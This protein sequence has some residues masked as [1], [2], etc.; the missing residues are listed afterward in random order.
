MTSEIVVSNYFEELRQ[1]IV[2]YGLSDKPHMIFNV[3]EKGISQDHTPPHVISSTLVHPPAVTSGKSST[4]TI[5]GCGMAVPSY[6]VF[7]GKRMMSDLMTDSTPG[8]DDCV[9]DS[10]WSNSEVFRNYLE[11]HFLKFVPCHIDQKILLLLD[12][13]KLHISVGL[14]EWANAQGIILYILPAHTSHRLQPMDVGCYGLLQRIYNSLCH[15]FIRETSGAITR[16]NVCE[17]ACKAYIRAL[18]AENLQAAFRRTGIFSLNKDA[19]AKEYFISAQVFELEKSVDS[20]ENDNDSDTVEGGVVVETENDKDKTDSYVSGSFFQNKENELRR[21][22]SELAS[23]KS[24][25]Q[26][27]K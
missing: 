25:K 5:L 7:P 13:H 23:K 2:K 11:N 18:S 3:D 9:T 15:K 27:V 14:V 4:V 19:I 21:A 22:K 24:R 16:Y 17:L 10:G 26:S 8:A 1:I 6:F 20:T 12:G